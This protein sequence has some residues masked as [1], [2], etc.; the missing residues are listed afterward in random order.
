MRQID[1]TVPIPDTTSQRASFR[2]ALHAA[3]TRAL[4]RRLFLCARSLNIRHVSAIWHDLSDRSGNVAISLALMCVPITLSV[5]GAIDYSRAVHFRAEV[6][7][8]VDSAALAGATAFVNYAAANL[9]SNVATEFM[10][11]GIA[12]LPTNNGV[13]FSAP[14]LKII[15]VASQP[16]AYQ[17]SLTATANVGTTFLGIL[18]PSIPVTVSA[19]AE[20]P[21]VSAAANFSGFSSSAT[22]TRT[23]STWAP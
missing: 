10:N 14:S 19:T 16:A 9:A 13:S 1:L 2:L 8:V 5:G 22:R 17:V 7:G 18:M 6:Q 12:K 4:V 23:R 21:V 20:N 11:A 3:A 15:T